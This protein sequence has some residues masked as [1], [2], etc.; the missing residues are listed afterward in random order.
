MDYS[1]PG[2][3]SCQLITG[4]LNNKFSHGQEFVSCPSSRHLSHPGNEVPLSQ[5][6]KA[7]PISKTNQHGRQRKSP[8]SISF[9]P[10]DAAR[11]T[12]HV[13]QPVCGG[14][15][16]RLKLVNPIISE[17]NYVNEFSYPMVHFLMCRAMV[18]VGVGSEGS[19]HEMS[20]RTC[21]M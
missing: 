20:V 12:P 15:C 5:H 16:Y 7:Y 2:H 11:L 9:F 6:P 14:I 21:S 8:L 13:T 18:F 10:R 19:P 1:I 3:E 4:Q 17:V